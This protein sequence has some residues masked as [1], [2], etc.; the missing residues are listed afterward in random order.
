MSILGHSIGAAVA[1]R[2]VSTMDTQM[3]PPIHSVV[4]SAPFTSVSDMAS[5]LFPII[6]PFLARALLTHNWD[7]KLAMSAFLASS[8]KEKIYVVHGT[9][10]E[11]VPFRMSQEICKVDKERITHVPVLLAD[12][13]NVL[14]NY[15]LYTRVL[16]ESEVTS[17]L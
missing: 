17:K 10:D 11:I 7:N 8:L 6:P 5:V 13:N 4:L 1:L 12:H 14:G 3:T 16:A 15:Q 2:W 9:L